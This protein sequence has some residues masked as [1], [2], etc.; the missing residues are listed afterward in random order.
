M[1]D[2]NEKNTNLSLSPPFDMK[3]MIES[4]FFSG[5]HSEAFCLR[6]V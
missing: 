5:E 4:F 3:V 6:L 2:P 1:L